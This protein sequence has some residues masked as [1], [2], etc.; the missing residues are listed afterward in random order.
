MLKVAKV[1]SLGPNCHTSGIIKRLKYKSESYPF[2]WIISDTN[3]VIDCINDDFLKYLNKDLYFNNKNLVGHTEYKNNMFVHRDPLS[4]EEDY[5]YISRCV[6]RFK[7]LYNKNDILFV[8]T[9]YE[10][11]VLEDFIKLKSVLDRKI[12]NCYLLILN[13]IKTDEYENYKY[14]ISNNYE[15]IYSIHIN[16]N[17]DNNI[18]YSID[19][20]VLNFFENH[21][22]LTEIFAIKTNK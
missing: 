17:Y 11:Y 12:N 21:N 8:Y 2:D 3:V 18:E 5:N 9:V 1:V 16:I 10:N 14:K 22:P 13:Y 19:H 15:N 4:N 20:S 6:D 7:E